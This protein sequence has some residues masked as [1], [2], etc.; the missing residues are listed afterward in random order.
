MR[1][2]LAVGLLILAAATAPA[3]A[4]DTVATFD[5]T[6]GELP[7]GIAF[8]RRGNLYVS[9]APLGEI[10]RRGDDGSWA[11]F[12]SIGPHSAGGLAI[13]GL[14]VDSH[15]SLLAAAPTD[16]PAWHGVV[17][18]SDEG[19]MRRVPGTEQMAFP[20]ALAIAPGGDL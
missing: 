10:R 15:G 2:L 1:R 11:S 4:G 16:K 18:I 5:V 6:R 17:A 8:D 19:A 13:L 12:A 14:T 9:L 7:E 3:A 20:N